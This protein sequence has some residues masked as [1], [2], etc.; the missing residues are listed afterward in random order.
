MKA[1]DHHEE[2]SAKLYKP[3]LFDRSCLHYR[4]FYDSTGTIQ[5]K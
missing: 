5:I 4:D 2:Y 1:L 3:I